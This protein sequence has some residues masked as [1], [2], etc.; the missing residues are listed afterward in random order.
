MIDRGLSLGQE[1]DRGGDLQA[2]KGAAC[3]YAK[4]YAIQYNFTIKTF[5]HKGL[6][7]FFER[8]S[9]AGIQPHLRLGSDGNWLGLTWPTRRQI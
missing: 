5:R 4:R 1:H 3:R 6:Q 7:V 9:K 8:G 2:R